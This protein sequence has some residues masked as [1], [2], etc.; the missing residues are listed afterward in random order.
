MKFLCGS[1]ETNPTSIHE[2][3]GS[4]PVL[5]PWVKDPAIPRAAVGVAD[6]DGN[7][8]VGRQLIQPLAWEL[9]HATGMAPPSK[10][11]LF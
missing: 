5:T 2:D 6:R 11:K 4:I 7:W 10:K 3:A 1:A 8:C 9:P